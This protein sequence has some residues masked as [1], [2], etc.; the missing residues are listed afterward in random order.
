M[1]IE[2]LPS[3][4][5]TVSTVLQRWPFTA[6]VFRRIGLGDC[7]GCVMGSYESLAEVSATYNVDAQFVLQ[8]LRSAVMQENAR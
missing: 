5:D 1:N 2:T 8:E 6:D 3:L 4:D 7:I